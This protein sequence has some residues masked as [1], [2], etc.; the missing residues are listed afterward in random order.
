LNFLAFLNP[1][2]RLETG[3]LGMFGLTRKKF[4]PFAP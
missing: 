2:A 3:I 4:S 1:G